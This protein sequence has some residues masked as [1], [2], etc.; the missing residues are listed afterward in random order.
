MSACPNL[1]RA[2][3]RVLP[4]LTQEAEGVWNGDFCFVQ[5]AD[6]QYGLLERYVEKKPEPW[7][8]EEEQRR[9]ELAVAKL[10]AMDPAPKFFVICGDLIDAYPGWKDRP[11][12]LKTFF[13]VRDF[14]F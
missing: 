12:Q 13:E 8:W 5:A 14:L 1:L 6:T 7:G 10:N 9:S 3:N 11:A 2:T 4:K